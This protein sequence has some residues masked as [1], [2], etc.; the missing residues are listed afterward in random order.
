[1]FSHFLVAVDGSDHSFRAVE[2]AARLTSSAN[3]SRITLLFVVTPDSRGTSLLQFERITSIQKERAE[4]IGR[5]EALLTERNVPYQVVIR[6]GEAGPVIVK[7]ANEIKPDMLL[8][9]SRGLNKMQEFV[10]GSVS[11]KVMKRAACPV[12]IVK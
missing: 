4:R 6:E 3:G 5:H 9:G 7:Y 10:L 11:H 8:I 1:M 2:E 12:M